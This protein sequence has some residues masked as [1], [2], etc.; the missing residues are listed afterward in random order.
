MTER[1]GRKLKETPADAAVRDAVLENAGRRLLE[2][3]VGLEELGDRIGELR[4]DVK[5]R[6]DAAKSEGYSP[7]AIKA[8]LK[9]RA[10]TP[11]ALKAQEE[12][13]LQVE[14]YEAALRAAE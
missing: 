7:G 3:V 9:K 1:K 4:T 5:T 2:I 8:L 14:T 10:A 13:F 6:M 12:L 11:E